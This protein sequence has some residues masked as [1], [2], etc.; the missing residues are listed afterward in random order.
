MKVLQ[1]T[2]TGFSEMTR[3]GVPALT[4]TVRYEGGV[5]WRERGWALRNREERHTD[6]LIC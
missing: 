4:I 1:P 5:S 2:V 6:S 3:E